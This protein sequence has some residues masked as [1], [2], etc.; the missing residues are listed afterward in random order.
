MN[1]SPG[2]LRA[3]RTLAAPTVLDNWILYLHGA[4]LD[5]SLDVIII[6]SVYGT[7]AR[8]HPQIIV[9]LFFEIVYLA[10][11]TFGN[12]WLFEYLLNPSRSAGSPPT[13]TPIGTSSRT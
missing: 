2:I 10:L 4:F 7:S 6:Y 12:P 13:L 11:N 1:M 9:Q 3:F 5:M 8:R